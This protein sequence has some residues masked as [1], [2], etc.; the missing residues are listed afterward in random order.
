MINLWGPEFHVA[1]AD[2]F[3]VGIMTSWIGSPFAIAAKYSFQ[4][5]NPKLNFSLGEIV[6]NGGYIDP[7]TFLSLSFGNVTFGDREKNLTFGLGYGYFDFNQTQ[8]VPGTYPASQYVPQRSKPASQGIIGSLAASVRINEKTSF[9]FDSMFGLMKANGTTTNYNYDSWTQTGT[10]VVTA[11]KNDTPFFVFMPAL[12]RSQGDGRA[13]Q[14][15][16]AGINTNYVTRPIP[17]VSWYR[18]L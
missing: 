12:R 6:G 18:T 10:V 7:S 16:L 2:N 11:N 14:F 1:V 8:N 17:F 3:N 4:T 15:T 5:K 13:I 9:V